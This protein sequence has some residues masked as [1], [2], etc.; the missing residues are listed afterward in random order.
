MIPKILDRLKLPHKAGVYI[1]KDGKGRTLYVG[2]AIDL[3]HRVASYFSASH[4]KGVSVK[5][6]ALV[7]KISSVDAIVVESELE[8]LI[9][10]ANLIKKYLP[11]YNVRLTDDKDYLYIAITKENF[12]KVITARKA[13][14]KGVKK[15]WGPFPSAR[16]VRDTLKKLRRVFPWCSASPSQTRRACFY[17]HLG[18]CA[19]AC[20]GLVTKDEY[21]SIIRNFSR[22]LD[23][24]KE[25]LVKDI[26]EQMM[27]VSS[28]QKFEEAGKFKRILDGINYMTQ[29]NRV[30]FYLDNPNFLQEERQLAL[31]QLRKDL[32][33]NKLP[34][35]I[36]A[37]DISNIQGKNA[38]GSMVVLTDGDIDKSQYRRFK[39]RAEGRPNDVGMM[40][41]MVIRRFSHPEW[42]SPDLVLVDG[43]R[44]QAK[45]AQFSIFNSQFS[46]PVFGLAKKTEW[47]YPPEGGVIRLSRKSLSLRLLQKIR[48][49]AHRF[50]ISY[51]R[52]LRDRIKETSN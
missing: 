12:P 27:R 39:I 11:P 51:H 2:K 4:P 7:E 1:F 48:D 28:E 6:A 47:L 3:Y 46:I 35:R 52:K 42:P 38:V 49:E 19:G 41:E 40:K 18:L 5:I 24:K 26:T 45:A 29:T 31:E 37:F 32:D 8:A 36:E 15:Y 30:Q 20:I 25:E 14:L 16:T 17:Y 9:L 13:Q 23:G 50:A 33:L 43:G 44:G 22:F 34:Q 10:E 21:S